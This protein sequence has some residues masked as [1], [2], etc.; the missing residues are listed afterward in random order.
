[1]G[2]F[3]WQ[4]N[5]VNFIVFL[6][7]LLPFNQ[8]IIINYSMSSNYIN[9]HWKQKNKNSI[10]FIDISFSITFIIT[11]HIITSYKLDIFLKFNKKLYTFRVLFLQNIILFN[12][13]NVSIK[14]KIWLLFIDIKSVKDCIVITISFCVKKIFNHSWFLQIIRI[15]SNSPY[16]NSITT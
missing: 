16:L 6:Y 9:Y 5:K 12:I 14:Y 10:R 15:I 8:M 1:M 11:I 4:N 3:G 13:V 2:N 7:I